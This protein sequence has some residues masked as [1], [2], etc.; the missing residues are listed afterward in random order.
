MDTPSSSAFEPT[1]EI[2]PSLST[3]NSSRQLA[4]NLTSGSQLTSHEQ[5]LLRVRLRIAALV[6][7]VG[8]SL[9]LLMW[10]FGFSDMMAN[11]YVMVSHLITTTTLGLCAF[12][13]CRT[14]HA[15]QFRLRIE[16]AIVF[17]M[18]AAFFALVNV[19]AMS[20]CAAEHGYLPDPFGP[21]MMLAFTYALFIPN[22]IQ[23]AVLII[24]SMSIAPV[25]ILAVMMATSSVCQHAYNADAVFLVKGLLEMTMT[26]I[27]AATGAA[28]I[29]TLRK[30]AFAAKELGQYRLKQRIGRG[31][32]GE[33][34]LAEHRLIKR[35]CAVKIIRSDRARD[36]Q[37]IARFER[38]VQTV[39]NLTH[40]NSVN[41][42]DYGHT[43]DGTFYFVMEYLPGMSLQQLV[44][45]YGPMPAGRVIYFLRQIC[46]ALQEAHN[47]NFV[48]R[49]LKPA[50]IFAAHLGGEHDVAK[51]LD[52]GLAKDVDSSDSA[53]LTM[54]G[55]IAGSPLFM[56]PENATGDSEPDARS[57]IYS[58]G[59]VAY[60]LL[61]GQPPFPGQ[62]PIKILMA[63]VNDAVRRPSDVRSTVSSDLEQVVL[64]CL[65]KNP[66]DRPQSA[67]KLEGLLA[68]CVDADQWSRTAANEWWSTVRPEGA[69]MLS[70]QAEDLAPTI[71]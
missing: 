20:N 36:P 23:R 37:A 66:S 30:E 49:D 35:P 58:L 46:D 64:Q 63:H 50:N 27:I 44:E 21:W 8:F 65:E 12:S 61:T 10:S 68:A 2:T 16:E 71:G 40:W 54:L 13:L 67:A 39:A 69:D 57:D 41:V 26:A 29:G 31:G 1:I 25:V 70:T 3:P 56:A 4:L 28:K 14:C 55:T 60:Y 42:Y 45:K 51:L 7:F 62:Q 52:F 5:E 22:R 34:Y 59:C 32:M 19:M 6:L 47:M 43:E 38:E 11:T 9:F 17:G 33:V 53:E 18:P 15:N 24:V 48:H